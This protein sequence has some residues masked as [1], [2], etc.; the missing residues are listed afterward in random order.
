MKALFMTLAA[1][2]LFLT[3]A[4]AAALAD[5]N[6]TITNNGDHTIEYIYISAVDSD[7][8]G[9]DWLDSDQVLGSDQH[10]TFTIQSGC[11]QDIKVVYMNGHSDVTRNFDTCQYDLRLNY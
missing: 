1:A 11:D 10:I 7:E 8:W 9:N 2:V 3:V 4:P 6:L 5:H